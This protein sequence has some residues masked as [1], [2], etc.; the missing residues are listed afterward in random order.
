MANYIKDFLTKRRLTVYLHEAIE[1]A[2]EG[3]KIRLRNLGR[4]IV[5]CKDGRLRDEKGEHVCIS[6]HEEITA[7]DWE[8]VSEEIE[9]GDEI[10][11]NDEIDLFKKGTLCDVIEVGPAEIKVRT[12]FEFYL[13]SDQYTLIR[14]G[15]VHTFEGVGFM[16]TGGL[17]YPHRGIDNP[18]YPALIKLVGKTYKMTLEEES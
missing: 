16:D 11:L 13:G 7:T 5:I 1:K 6:Q 14:K 9:V 2:G 18:L 12:Y 10:K 15:K 17:V 8:V 3:G 4:I